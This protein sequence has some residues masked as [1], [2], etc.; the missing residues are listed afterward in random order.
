MIC[1]QRAGGGGE[2]VAPTLG[3]GS[4]ISGRGGAG[5]RE[6]E[7]LGKATGTLGSE[8]VGSSSGGTTAEKMTDNFAM[9]S[10]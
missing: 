8:A 1:G 7:G 9:A 10:I 5:W 2:A 4:H 6:G 3:S